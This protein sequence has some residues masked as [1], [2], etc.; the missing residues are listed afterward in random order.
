MVEA[1]SLR[2]HSITL[3]TDD[4]KVDFLGAKP[5]FRSDGEPMFASDPN[6]AVAT[7]IALHR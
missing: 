6:L 1:L 4:P 5:N 3:A 7:Q 2:A